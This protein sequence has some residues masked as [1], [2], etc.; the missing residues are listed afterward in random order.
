MVT[1]Y[2]IWTDWSLFIANFK[3]L[4]SNCCSRIFCVPIT[5]NFIQN[6]NKLKI[7]FKIKS[8]QTVLFLFFSTKH[9]TELGYQSHDLDRKLLESFSWIDN[10]NHRT[11]KNSTTLLN[12]VHICDDDFKLKMPSKIWQPFSSN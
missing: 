5:F 2:K 3:T 12:I 4:G 10:E 1:M 11:S 9:W 7:Y 6:L 8:K